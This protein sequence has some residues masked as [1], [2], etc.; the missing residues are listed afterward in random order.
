MPTRPLTGTVLT[1][2]AAAVA[3]A[4]LAWAALVPGVAQA[5]AA[6]A[7]PIRIGFL[8]SLTGVAAESGKDMADGFRL[9]LEQ[10]NFRMAGRPVEFIV[11]DTGGVPANALT[12]ARKL[13]EQDRVHVLA[14]PLLAN[15]GYAITDYVRQQRIPWVLPVMSGDDITQRQLNPYVVRM[16][17][18]SSQITHPFGEY[19]Y[20]EL[21]YRRVAT[22][23]SD[24][25]FSYE[26]VGG[27][28]RTFEELGGRVV[29]KLWSPV[30]APD[31]A[32]YLSSL[33]RDVD[34]V[35]VTMTGADVVRFMNQFN[36]FGLRRTLPLVGGPLMADESLLRSMGDEAVGL[37]TSHFWAAGL[38]RP[39]ARRFVEAFRARYNKIPSYYAETCYDGAMWIDRALQSIQGRVEDRQ[40]FMEAL[41]KVRLEDAPR[42]PIALDEY[43]NSIQNVYIRRVVKR[44]GILW[45]EVIHTIPNVTQFWKWSPQEFLAQPAYDRNFPP[46]RYCGQ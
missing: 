38:D 12:K 28:Q 46:C 8:T 36:M 13:V 43:H 24:Y 18:A 27:F 29:Q 39:Q 44:D 41:L 10:V 26:I 21:G 45:N 19:V 7:E 32:P 40:A 22:L 33:R 2:V 35:F 5:G 20:R 16:G 42:G 14:G 6:S 4:V 11:E 25:A 3:V 9:Y 15:E 31:F 37:L 30:G 1:V 34:A 17:W 23:G